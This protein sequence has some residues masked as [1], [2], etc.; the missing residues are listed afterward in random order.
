VLAGVGPLQLEVA[1]DRLEREFG[2]VVGIDPAPWTVARRTD[3]ASAP[4]IRR[5]SQGDVLFTTDGSLLA[6]FTSRHAL[7][8]FEL[9]HPT[10]TLAR[11]LVR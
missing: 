1:V 11:L 3:E 9:D 4:M 8:R 7:E 2:A 10:A 5:T 6:V